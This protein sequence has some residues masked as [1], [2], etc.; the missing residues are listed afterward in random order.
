[1]NDPQFKEVPHAVYCWQK[2]KPEKIWIFEKPA[3]LSDFDIHLTFIINL[4]ILP[5]SVLSRTNFRGGRICCVTIAGGSGI[6]LLN[7]W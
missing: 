3:D 5:T 7:K 1:M 4:Q 6:S 2:A